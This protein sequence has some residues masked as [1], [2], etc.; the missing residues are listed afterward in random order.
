MI[1]AG[2]LLPWLIAGVFIIAV[3]YASV[4]HAGAS[5]YIAVMSLLSVA[6]ATIKP[7]ALLLN[8]AVA[9]IGSVQFWR[10][11]YFRWPLFWP[12]AL[13]AVPFA[14]L[15]GWLQLPAEG[16]KLLLG[17]ALLLSALNLLLR[18]PADGPTQAPP[19]PIALVTGAALGLLAG[20]TG[21]GG[22]IYL[23]PLMLFL[24]WAPMRQVAAV[25]AP[26]ILLNSLSGLAGHLLAG[27]A[28]PELAGALL[29]AVIC[30]GALGAWL[31]ARR[32]PVPLIK[33]VLALVLSIAGLKL[34]GLA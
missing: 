28:I 7:V 20:L 11:G 1:E 30:G 32:L 8:I 5:G 23:T 27:K 22:G 15:G 6:P 34:V 2:T 31:G 12:F 13:A 14:A 18:P 24:H 4:G 16:F 26:F 3:L 25:S 29:L 19:L 33:R 21:T 17:A 9:C 10:A